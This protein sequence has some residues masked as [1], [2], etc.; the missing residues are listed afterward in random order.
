MIDF[1]PL[2]KMS[3]NKLIEFRNR[4]SR[5]EYPKKV[6]MNVVYMLMIIEELLKYSENIFSDNTLTNKTRYTDLDSAIGEID[7]KTSLI[8]Q[9]INET[10]ASIFEK[11][12]YVM[13][14]D[15]ARIRND[16]NV[17][18][19]DPA[20]LENLEFSY[21]FYKCLKESVVLWL[22]FGL[23]NETRIS[24]FSKVFDVVTT[25][26]FEDSKNYMSFFEGAVQTIV[27]KYYVPLKNL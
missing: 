23:L 2:A 19:K 17:A 12:N 1:E 3:T 4:Y 25:K 18:L 20:R 5:N 26:A 11:S 27:P 21:V 24:A 8:V 6:A 9:R 14:I 10:V 15:L 13:H 22:A 16:V 7:N